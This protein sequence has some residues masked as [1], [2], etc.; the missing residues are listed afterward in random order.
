MRLVL[1]AILS[2]MEPSLANIREHNA[3]PQ[4][5]TSSGPKGLT[6]ND[7][8]HKEGHPFQWLASEAFLLASGLCKRP[9]QVRTKSA[10]FH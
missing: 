7:G 10:F 6:G 2:S 8:G 4:N 3:G 1:T 5:E 9:V